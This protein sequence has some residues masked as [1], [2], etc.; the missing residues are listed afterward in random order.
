M[1]DSNLLIWRKIFFFRVLK[2]YQVLE[3][4][5]WRNGKNEA[6]TGARSECGARKQNCF[7]SKLLVLVTEHFSVSFLH[8]SSSQ[9]H[10]SYSQQQG[11]SPQYK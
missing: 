10:F 3:T 9:K 8:D 6:V 2:A 11:I 5:T 1:N 7:H 4:E